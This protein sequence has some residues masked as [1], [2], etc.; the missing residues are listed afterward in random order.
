MDE[1]WIKTTDKK[2]INLIRLTRKNTLDYIN[3]D[4]NV[5]TK[6]TRKDLVT[7][8]DKSNEQFLVNNIREIDPKSKILGE[9]GFGDNVNSMSGHVWIIDPIDGTMNFVKEKNHFAI[10]LALYIDGKGILGYILD[11]MQNKLY[12]GIFGKVYENDKEIFSPKNISLN[13]GLMG[14][15]APLLIND[16]DNMQSIAHKSSGVRIYGSAGI[17]FISVIKGELIGYISHLKPWDI[18]AGKVMCDSLGI[19]VTTIDGNALD[20][21]SSETVLIATKI[22][23]KEI[24]DLVK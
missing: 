22:A 13:N 7:N 21:V 18:A 3:K 11:V 1:E 19:T 14:M 24:L 10:M 15:S 23:H 16:Y 20:M 9:E 12:H 4:I 2:I 17:Q 6:T 8:V 5:S